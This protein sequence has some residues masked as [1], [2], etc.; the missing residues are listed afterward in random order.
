MQVHLE[1]DIKIAVQCILSGTPFDVLLYP[2]RRSQVP[3][4]SMKI[5]T[6]GRP[7]RTLM[8]ASLLTRTKEICT[9]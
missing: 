5:A 7:K 2:V 8:L 3:Y 9:A 4:W 6:L 1:S